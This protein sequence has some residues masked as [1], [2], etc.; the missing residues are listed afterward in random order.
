MTDFGNR[1]G[2]RCRTAVGVL[3]AAVVLATGLT[4][5]SKEGGDEP[6]FSAPEI[7][8][9]D[10][11]VA[12]FQGRP[13]TAGEIYHKI[14]L[15]YPQMPRSGPGLGLQAKELV[16]AVV[17]ERCVVAYA[18]ERGLDRTPDYQRTLHFSDRFIL[19]RTAEAAICADVAPSEEELRAWYEE[20]LD[21]FTVPEQLWYHQIQVGS[22]MQ[23]E[24]ICRQLASGAD[25]EAL[26]RKFSRDTESAARGGRMLPFRDDGSPTLPARQ[27]RLAQALRSLGEGGVSPPVKGESDW[28]VLRLDA[29][30][31]AY[32]KDFEE[33]REGLHEKIGGSRE[34][35]HLS[36]VIDSLKR[37]YRVKYHEENL[38]R[39]YFLQMDA[40]QLAQAVRGEQDPRRR[41]RMYEEIVARFP[42]DDRH[43]EALFMIGF[44]YAENLGERER[45]R[46][47]FERFLAEYP[48]HALAASAKTMLATLEGGGGPAEGGAPAET[49]PETGE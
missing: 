9:S 45:A 34:V 46:E 31:A 36:S 5:C 15:Q 44:E 37:A 48:G 29:R 30:R 32:V 49:E 4:G 20:H 1:F 3:A 40:E 11:V 47:T 14:R 43:A 28:H 27:P 39:F 24:D 26:A 23:A 33:L 35:D 8:G 22:Q 41:I 25:F 2:M 42:G 38:D 18:R 16:Q 7:A 10:L 19:N 6:D 12:E 13:I 17:D 21:Q